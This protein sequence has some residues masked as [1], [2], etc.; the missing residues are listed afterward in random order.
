MLKLVAASLA[1]LSVA[2]GASAQVGQTLPPANDAL[3]GN[4][5]NSLPLANYPAGVYQTMYGADLLTEIPVGSVIT[6]MQLRLSKPSSS[7]FP[8]GAYVV[9]RYD[10]QMA[11]SSLTP[12]S[13]SSTFLTNMT[14]SVLVRSGPLNVAAG[15]YQWINNGAGVPQPWGPVIPFT[16]GYVY[17]GG[18][19]VI[20]FRVQ[21]PSNTFAAYADISSSGSQRAAYAESNADALSAGI[22][23]IAGG[24]VVRLTVAPP[25]TD[26]ARGVTKVIVGEDFANSV[27]N[28]SEGVLIWNAAYTQQ[29]IAASSQF[30]TIGPASD[31]VGMAWR[32]SSSI[33]GASW[34]AAIANFAQYDVQLS[35]SPNDPSSLS[36][37]IATNVGPDAV[38]VRSGPLS[39]AANSFGTK[40][41]E[42]TSPFGP[43]VGFA[44]AYH[45]RGGSLLTVTR[46]TGQGSGTIDFL[47]ASN[48]LPGSPI[49]A[50]QA[51]G[52][53]VATAAGISGYGVTRYSVDAG[54]SSPL[55]QPSP[56]ASNLGFNYWPRTV[57]TVIAASELQ[58]I[59]VGSVIDSMWLRVAIGEASSP[60]ATTSALDFEVDVS[61]ATVPPAT[62]SNTFASNEGA[63]KVRVFD[64]PMSILAG[65]LPAASNGNYGKL[66]QFQKHF[67]YKGGPLCVKVRHTGL[68]GSGM[69]GP[70]AQLGSLAINNS[71]YSDSEGAVSGFPLGSGFDGLSMKLGYIPS[72]M[73]PNNLATTPGES[74]PAWLFP[75]ASAGVVQLIVAADQLRGIDVGSAITGMSLRNVGV[76]SFPSVDTNMTRFDVTLAPAAVA[77]LSVSGTFASNNGPGVVTVRTGALTIPANAFPGTGSP[78]VAAENAWYVPFQRAFVYPGGNLCMTLRFEGLLAALGRIDGDG[79]VPTARGAGVY[80]Y[81]NANATS[82]S[83]W[84]PMGVRFAFTAQAFCPWDLNNDG[85]VSDDDFPIFLQGYNILDC[86]ESGMPQG[87]PADFNYDGAVDDADFGL[88]VLA[89]NALLCP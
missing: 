49:R 23:P 85:I 29:A 80:F 12:A 37:T 51:Q 60:V 35:R 79:F 47:D 15:A 63:D 17:Q 50:L 21:S 86:R 87:C 84:G 18:P 53:A 59:P 9:T 42:I 27:P 71:R 31:F 57:Q 10:V 62:M 26:L 13:M 39:L 5:G 61:T 70:E 56:G 78:S 32:R 46:H 54:T 44:N 72:V 16:T 81:A 75:Q 11:G 74:G 65:T 38:T 76:A 3:A 34:P 88:F 19:L 58:H 83:T 28:A 1:S 24:V 25:P 36:S 77:P 73:T 48:F 66:V 55:N 68:S 4:S 43:E 14:G 40:G 7:T 52:F 8:L 69:R 67:V 30:D 33:N 45:Y 20:E 2:C 89:Y 64:G 82:G 41:S 6:G 22:G